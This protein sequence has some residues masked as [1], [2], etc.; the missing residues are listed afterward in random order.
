MCL[1]TRTMRQRDEARAGDAGPADD[2]PYC[3]KK[4]KK[5][6]LTT[7]FNSFASHTR[8][9]NDSHVHTQNES[10]ARRHSLDTPPHTIDES[11]RAEA[12][13]AGTHTLARETRTH[14]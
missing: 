2:P 11:A 12:R 1:T 10:H 9:T 6:L 3:P 4:K 13:S 14:V 8:R 5:V 7:S